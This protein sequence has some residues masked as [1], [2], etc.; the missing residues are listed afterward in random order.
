MM[1]RA[2]LLS[3][4]LLGAVAVAIPASSQ[5]PAAIVETGWW[6]RNPAAGPKDSDE[7]FEAARAPDGP[8]SVA[9]LQ[10]RVDSAPIERALLVASE[11][12]GFRQDAAAL[13]VCP[14]TNLWEAENG[15]SF[16]EA[17]EPDCA[18]I[19]VPLERD[20]DAEVWRGDVAGLL[21]GVGEASVMV[22]PDPGRDG[23][24]LDPGF[25]VEFGF[26]TLDARAAPPPPTFSPPP[27]AGTDGETGSDRRPA[28]PMPETT[29]TSGAGT[30]PPPVPSPS[31]EPLRDAPAQAPG[32]FP[33]RPA[34]ELP[35]EADPRPWWRLVF[36]VPLSG[37]VG[38]AG[39][40]GRR[41]LVEQGILRAG[42]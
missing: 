40:R 3:G 32:S 39:A 15:G 42:V 12:G 16:D 37:V 30:K 2:L 34:A 10:I 28:R 22:V 31:G 1:V 7:A 5:Q 4:V 23:G 19:A 9:A 38:L 17:P 29:V 27:V 14:T 21:G 8:L 26:A 36:L 35:D 41:I 11:S 33:V 6:T 13:A 25:Q 24:P 18:G 20:G